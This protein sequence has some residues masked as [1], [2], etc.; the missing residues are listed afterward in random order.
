MLDINF[1]HLSHTGQWRHKMF[2]ISTWFK[3]ARACPAIAD[4][5]EPKLHPAQFILADFVG[6]RTTEP[7]VPG[8][9][10]SA[11]HSWVYVKGETNG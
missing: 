7:L 8:F 10:D 1:Q 11:G 4:L 9:T 5:P 6:S 2:A 3:K